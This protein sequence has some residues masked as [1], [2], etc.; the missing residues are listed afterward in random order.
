MIMV[1]QHSASSSISATHLRPGN[2]STTDLSDKVLSLVKHNNNYNSLK[3]P[4][5]GGTINN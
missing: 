3:E 2:Q 5:G 1:Q 4:G